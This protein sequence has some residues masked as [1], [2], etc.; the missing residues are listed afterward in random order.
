MS[1]RMKRKLLALSCALVMLAACSDDPT[2]PSADEGVSADQDTNQGKSR[3]SGGDNRPQGKA[4]SKQ[5][6][7]KSSGGSGDDGGSGAK[8]GGASKDD[9]GSDPQEET[10]A[11]SDPLPYPAAGKY[12]YQ[13]SGY[14][15]FCQTTSCDKKDLP[16]EQAVEVSYKKKSKDRATVV[17]ESRSSNNRVTRTTT[18]FTPTVALITEVYTR[19]NYQDVRF[20]DTYR[21]DP[22]VEALRFPLRSGMSWSGQWKDTTSGDYKISVGKKTGDVYEIT[23]KI[24]FRGQFEGESHATVWFD[25]V[26]KAIVRSVGR[27][28]VK[29]AFGTYRSEFRTAL[30]SGPGY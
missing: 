7:G 26:H 24:T 4:S 15:E 9:G 11:S 20:E 6:N 14:E 16:A 3:G 10:T 21:P 30:K 1:S 5:D 23:T 17:S 12:V 2:L 19:F 25:S 18:K 13:Q 27:L 22:P 29:S 28:N 8:A